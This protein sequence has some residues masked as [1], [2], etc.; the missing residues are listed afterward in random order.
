VRL[1]FAAQQ[2][3]TVKYM[4]ASDSF[5]SLTTFNLIV[6][7]HFKISLFSPNCLINSIRR[8]FN[9]H[10]ADFFYGFDEGEREKI[11][12]VDVQIIHNIFGFE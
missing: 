4:H 8:I 7:K 12:R 6:S 3:P 2:L 11:A 10:F 1:S 5:F 9:E